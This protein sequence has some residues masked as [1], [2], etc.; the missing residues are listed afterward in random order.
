[1]SRLRNEFE[2]VLLDNKIRYTKY[3]IAERDENIVFF[4]TD[5][6][7]DTYLIEFEPLECLGRDIHEFAKETMAPVFKQMKSA[8]H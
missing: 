8:Y 7:D 4:F 2:G 6:K 1:M 5:H 3:G